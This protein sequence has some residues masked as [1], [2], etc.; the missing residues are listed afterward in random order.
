M[1]MATYPMKDVGFYVDHEVAAYILLATDQAKNIVPEEIAELLDAGT[2]ATQAKKGTLPCDYQC[3]F[4]AWNC[5]EGACYAS[6]FDGEV[7]TLLSERAVSPIEETFDDDVL[8]YIPAAK[9]AELFKAAYTSPEELLKE[10]KT[11]FAEQEI[12]FPDDFDW[13][14]HIVSI[15]GTYFC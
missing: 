12:V 5:F 3:T 10:F 4:E 1:G 6:S 8:A 11:A 14:A 9:E 7:S 13:W 2:F 15:N